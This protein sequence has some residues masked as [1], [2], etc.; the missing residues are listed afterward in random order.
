VALTLPTKRSDIV[1]TAG[2]LPNGVYRFTQTREILDAVGAPATDE[3]FIGEFV[4]KDGTA[5]LRYFNID[6]SPMAGEPPDTGGST[7][8]RATS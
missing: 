8:C 2:D 4:L 1:P 5:E 7:R 6:S 3:P